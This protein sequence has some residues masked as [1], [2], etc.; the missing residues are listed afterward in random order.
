MT[1][2]VSVA[3]LRSALDLLLREVERRHGPQ[4]DLDGGLYWTVWPGKAHRFD[5][6]PPQ[7][8]VGDLTDDVE[9]VR[10][11]LSRDPD[12]G[13]YVWHDLTHV[14]GVLTRL[15]ALDLPDERR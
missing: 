14:V 2:V 7:V 13:V 11:L 10:E 9:S 3:E 6:E 4:V 5:G 8:T 1:P 12:E 15:A